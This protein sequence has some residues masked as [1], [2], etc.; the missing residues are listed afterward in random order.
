MN[1]EAIEQEIQDK[2]LAARSPA[3][4]LATRFGRSKATPCANGS[5]ADAA[6]GM[7]TRE[8]MPANAA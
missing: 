3:A 4:T 1:E 8:L 7:K 6:A 5:R 2:G